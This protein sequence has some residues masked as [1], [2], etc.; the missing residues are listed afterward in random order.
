MLFPFIAGQSDYNPIKWALLPLSDSY[1][2]AS[3]FFNSERFS[4]SKSGRYSLKRC[5]AGLGGGFCGLIYGAVRAGPYGLYKIVKAA[6]EPVKYLKKKCISGAN[7]KLELSEDNPLF[8]KAI[9]GNNPG[10]AEQCINDVRKA[11][12][13]ASHDAEST[14]GRVSKFRACLSS[15]SGQS[16]QGYSLLQGDVLDDLKEKLGSIVSDTLDKLYDDIFRKLPEDTK[17]SIKEFLKASVIGL[18][19]PDKKD[20]LLSP[21]DAALEEKEDDDIIKKVILKHKKIITTDLIRIAFN[22]L[23][24]YHNDKKAIKILKQQFNLEKDQV[25]FLEDIQKSYET[26]EQSAANTKP[27]LLE[28][29]K[30]LKE[31]SKI[32][33]KV[34]EKAFMSINPYMWQGMLRNKII[35]LFEDTFKPKPGVETEERVGDDKLARLSQCLEALPGS[36]ALKD[37]MC[38]PDADADANIGP[39]K[40]LVDALIKL[41]NRSSQEA[42]ELLLQEFIEKYDRKEV[43]NEK[44]K[45]LNKVWE[46]GER[47]KRHK[48][49]SS[50]EVDSFFQNLES[51]TG[52]INDPG[53]IDS[54]N[55][56][57]VLAKTVC[58][59]GNPTQGKVD[60][61][62]FYKHR[63]DLI[64][65]IER[66]REREVQSSEGITDSYDLL[67][68]QIN[69]FYNVTMRAIVDSMLDS[70][71]DQYE[72]NNPLKGSEAIKEW[73]KEIYEHSSDKAI[74]KDFCAKRGQGKN[75]TIKILHINLICEVLEGE[76]HAQSAQH[77]GEKSGKDKSSVIK[78]TG[79]QKLLRERQMHDNE[80]GRDGLPSSSLGKVP[81]HT[82]QKQSMTLRWALSRR[83]KKEGAECVCLG[84]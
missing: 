84:A 20:I 39:L 78:K 35:E 51:F 23:D 68:Q 45:V 12:F 37:R 3:L 77:T 6:A 63:N 22:L 5:L 13:Q 64:R 83:R 41:N 7:D 73:L 14:P 4:K 58:N 24:F 28:V 66:K 79:L 36:K 80:V 71:E 82:I 26:G 69:D 67:M 16:Q 76:E 72:V 55:S 38:K 75:L 34:S 40:N 59:D 49:F 46:F 27:Y 74:W 52:N 62:S 48:T 60:I 25:K 33:Q 61:N 32:V 54:L 19:T 2:Y 81:I 43:A 10:V 29:E 65:K 15:C 57:K 50:T 1:K 31:K 30:K 42:E 9:P 17:K 56:F 18:I 21:V 11:I 53:L 44:S 8:L 47:Q 70:C